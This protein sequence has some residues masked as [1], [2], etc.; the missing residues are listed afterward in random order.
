MIAVPV[1][2]EDLIQHEVRGYNMQTSI[3]SS[4]NSLDAIEL[5]AEKPKQSYAAKR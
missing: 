3:R 5:R 1:K 4:Y 2:W